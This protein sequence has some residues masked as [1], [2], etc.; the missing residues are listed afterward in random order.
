M[1]GHCRPICRT[2]ARA[3]ILAPDPAIDGLRVSDL[4]PPVSD[5]RPPEG[6]NGR[7][8]PVSRP[9]WPIVPA[10][11][12]FAAIRHFPP[13]RGSIWGIMKVFLGSQGPLLARNPLIVRSVGIF[14]CGHFGSQIGSECTIVPVIWQF[15][16]PVCTIVNATTI[17]GRPSPARSRRGVRPHLG[18]RGVRL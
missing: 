13:Y 11:P 3:S 4:R 17:R 15:D 14:V 10:G 9:I 8:P 7:F 2:H 16:P 12:K 6:E 1:R 18:S 5:L